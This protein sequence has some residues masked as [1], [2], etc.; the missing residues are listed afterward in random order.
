[1]AQR[2]AY[3]IAAIP[4]GFRSPAWAGRQALLDA[5]LATPADLARWSESFTRSDALTPRPTTFAPFFTAIGRRV[6]PPAG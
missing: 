1:M 4:P 2:G 6:T 3:L 5:G